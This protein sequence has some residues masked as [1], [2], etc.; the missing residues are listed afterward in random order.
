MAKLEDVLPYLSSDLINKTYNMIQN[1][2]V[3]G[4][5]ILSAIENFDPIEAANFIKEKA[6]DYAFDTYLGGDFDLM[7]GGGIN[8]D[9]TELASRI[10]NQAGDVALNELGLPVSTAN[11]QDVYSEFK[12]EGVGGGVKEMAKMLPELINKYGKDGAAKFIQNKL[13]YSNASLA[14]VNLILQTPPGDQLIK[15]G[16]DI[17]DT[18]FGGYGQKIGGFGKKLYNYPFDLLS[19]IFGNQQNIVP[20]KEQVVQPDPV[21]VPKPD[22]IIPPP[23]ATTNEAEVAYGGNVRDAGGSTTGS[24]GGGEDFGSPFQP[25][26]KPRPRPTH[27]F[28][29]G[30]LASM[31][32]VLR[33]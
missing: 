14:L 13:G 27:H 26:P 10:F 28:A 9:Q 19:G 4:T 16:S 20:V 21:I 23:P 7:T 33:R 12:E 2:T 25:K 31:A 6:T 29:Q 17:D 8:P 24:Y 11:V 3:T 15:M 30:G 32:R 5:G 22:P 18:F 1:P